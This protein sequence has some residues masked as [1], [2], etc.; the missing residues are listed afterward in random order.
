MP[1][2]AHVR[3]LW[4]RKQEC[5]KKRVDGRP[6]LFCIVT[7]SHYLENAALKFL[8]LSV[9]YELELADHNRLVL[10]RGL[11]KT[12]EID[13]HRGGDLRNVCRVGGVRLGFDHA[14]NCPDGLSAIH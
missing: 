3:T 4:H 2:P 14:G 7:I 8:R 12:P 13:A 1:L 9:R 11:L 10:C 5:S 6:I